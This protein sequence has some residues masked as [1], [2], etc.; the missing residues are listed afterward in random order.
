MS[1]RWPILGV[2]E[3][4]R[5][6][7]R[8][9]QIAL[10][11]EE[12][13]RNW[14]QFAPS[15]WRRLS[16]RSARRHNWEGSNFRFTAAT[17][18]KYL[19][20]IISLYGYYFLAETT[21]AEVDFQFFR[22]L[23]IFHFPPPPPHPPPP[24]LRRPAI[25]HFPVLSPRYE[26]IYTFPLPLLASG[27]HSV[28]SGWTDGRWIIYIYRSICIFVERSGKYWPAFLSL[29]S[30]NRESIDNAAVYCRSLHVRVKV[31]G[32]CLVI[33]WNVL[34]TSRK[35]T[36]EIIFPHEGKF[37]QKTLTLESLTHTHN[38]VL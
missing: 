5:K 22:L 26:Q 18:C 29:K 8:L 11:I 25:T 3:I 33:S 15:K 7:N 23:E 28:T 27:L 17:H 19:T 1:R 6:R 14:R 16:T 20:P 35:S 34:N 21:K 13:L 32:S 12:F 10:W 31:I 9:S 2:F 36:E 30:P 4:N 24:S 37:Q 38:C